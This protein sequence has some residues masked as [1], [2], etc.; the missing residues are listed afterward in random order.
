VSIKPFRFDVS[1]STKSYSTEYQEYE[2]TN[3]F[4]KEFTTIFESY[5]NNKQIEETSSKEQFFEKNS[6]FISKHIIEKL[7]KYENIPNAYICPIF[8]QLII[9][10]A[11]I[12]LSGHTYERES[13]I[14]CMSGDYFNDPF[15][16]KSIKCKTITPNRSLSSAL[17]L[18]KIKR[19]NKI[20]LLVFLCYRNNFFEQA[21]KAIEHG[22]IIA[23]K[24]KD[25]KNQEKFLHLFKLIENSLNFSSKSINEDLTKLA[26]SRNAALNNLGIYYIKGYGGEIN[27]KKA[28]F[29]FQLAA[30]QNYAPAQMSLGICFYFGFGVKINYYLAAF[31]FQLA[32]NQNYAPAQY[33]LGICFYYGLGVIQNYDNAFKCFQLAASQNYASA[34]YNLGICFYYGISGTQNYD[35]AFK[36]FQFAADQNFAPAQ[37]SLGLCYYYGIKVD[38][39]NDKACECFKLAANQNYAPAQ[40]ILGRYILNDEETKSNYKKAFEYFQLAANQKHTEAQYYLGLCYYYGLGVKIDYDKAIEY[41][42]LSNKTQSLT[43]GTPLK[44][45]MLTNKEIKLL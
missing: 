28:A 11:V 23:E 14:K 24:I 38:Q 45:Y 8:R 5:L 31:Y 44:F 6:E 7:E 18:F 1:I 29:Y 43:K 27:Y 39:N 16:G 32:A 4:L 10:P 19:I 40:Y 41:F 25:Q 34:Q 37:Y 33:N 35:N 17:E 36:C 20:I 9:D 2:K 15:T 22:K 13:I 26:I 12:P 42:Q 30:N 21:N 3:A